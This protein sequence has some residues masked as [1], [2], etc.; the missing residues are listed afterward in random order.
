MQS[1]EPQLNQGL[2]ATLK[3]ALIGTHRD[4]TEGSIGRAIFLLS[5]PMVLELVLESFFGLTNLFY[6]A[7]VKENA[8]EAM[9]TV[10]IVESLLAIVFTIGLG[11]SMAATA[12][13]ARRTGEKDE[14]GAAHAAAQAVWLAVLTSIPIA[15]LGIIATPLLMR[16]M[17]ADPKVIAVGTSYGV[18]IFG[19]NVLIM[20]LFIINACFRGTGD[21]TLAMR[22]LW[23]ASILNL[24]LDPCFIFGLGPFPEWGVTGSAVATTIG[25]SAG[26]IYQLW[27]LVN[28]KGRLKLRAEHFKPD[29]KLMSSMFIL[30]LGGMFQYFIGT[31]SWIAMA[32]LISQFGSASIAGYFVALRVIIF[33]ILPSW[34]MSNAAATLV[35]QNLGA[36][37]PDRA[38]KSVWMAGFS[39][40]IFLGGIGL[41]FIIFAEPL[42]GV[43]TSEP[44]VTPIAVQCLRIASYGYVF[45]AWGMV[46]VQSFNGAGDTF[47]PTVINLF[48]YWLFQIPLAYWLSNHF[49]M[50]ARGVFW[51]IPIAESM[52][53]VVGMLAFRRGT[54]R[55]IKV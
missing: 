13:V 27:S 15:F 14:E 49:G 33:A 19:T 7:R 55:T 22:S 2:V 32:R 5:V 44:T 11:L 1:T 3:E 53:A 29:F 39:N 46:M 51:A 10:G 50:E 54:W 6:V 20:M 37:K 17:G 43:F 26:V 8:T 41:L 12:I 18:I 42:V 34:G 24:I 47:T 48:C 52:I 23:M 38:E 16:L 31:A 36:G 45:Y 30:S 21:A 4:F 35:G 9:A 25:R 40:M 28:G